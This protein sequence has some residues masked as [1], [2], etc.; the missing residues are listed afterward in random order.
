L[1]VDIVENEE[2][3][4]IFAPV[5]G[6]SLKDIS[7]LVEDETLTISGERKNPVPSKEGN[8]LAKEC[9]W[10]L[11]SRSIILPT[12]ADKSKV[13]ASF[14]KGILKIKIPKK[15]SEKTRVVKIIEEK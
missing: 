13:K 3:I 5:S 14:S 8:F 7:V 4:L 12:I 11:F 10:G 6:V 15:E 9:F 1:S 2:S